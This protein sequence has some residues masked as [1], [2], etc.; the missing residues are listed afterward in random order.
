MIENYW[1]KRNIYFCFAFNIQ[2]GVNPAVTK[3]CCTK[4]FPFYFHPESL[5]NVP[6]KPVLMGISPC[7]NELLRSEELSQGP[8]WPSRLPKT[9][10]RMFSS[11]LT[12]TALQLKLLIRYHS[13]CVSIYWQSLTLFIISLILSLRPS[14]AS[15][16]QYLGFYLYP[17]PLVLPSHA[18]LKPI[19][20]SGLPALYHLPVLTGTSSFSVPSTE[21]SLHSLQEPELH[22][23]RAV[24]HDSVPML[25]L[26]SDS[27]HISHSVITSHVHT[28]IS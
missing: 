2:L 5:K 19:L 9:L 25:Y 26:G 3:I 21:F 14:V 13:A 1:R 18:F 20:S 23:W 8:F 4:V 17:F 6:R 22:S 28:P 7:A 11:S 27:Q 16:W 10:C 24:P 12:F 15:Y